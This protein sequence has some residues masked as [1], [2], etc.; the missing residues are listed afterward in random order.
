MFFS[1]VYK[2][3][4]YINQP[5]ENEKLCPVV[6][7]VIKTKSTAFVQSANTHRKLDI[8][9]KSDLN[10]EFGLKVDK[11]QNRRSFVSCAA[12]E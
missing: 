10:K 12:S 7:A 2:Q 8:N 3:G 11:G 6:P 1:L 5:G 4:C 9:V